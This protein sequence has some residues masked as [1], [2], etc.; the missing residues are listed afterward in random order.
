[1]RGKE[2]SLSVEGQG[3]SNVKWLIN[4][5]LQLAKKIHFWVA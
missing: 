2:S 4:S 3:A 1:M 5:R